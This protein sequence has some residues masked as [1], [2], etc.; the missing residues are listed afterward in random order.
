MLP[1]KECRKTPHQSFVKIVHSLVRR[2]LKRLQRPLTKRKLEDDSS[3]LDGQQEKT[4]AYH[5]PVA[6]QQEFPIRRPGPPAVPPSPKMD[7]AFFLFCGSLIFRGFCTLKAR[8]IFCRFFIFGL[9]PL[10]SL[11]LLE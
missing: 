10:H 11:S 1:Q 6:G 3:P 5:T 7:L 9:L 2:T 8:Q 4:R